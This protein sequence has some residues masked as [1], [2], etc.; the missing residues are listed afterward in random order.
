MVALLIVLA[1]GMCV[2]SCLAS[3]AAV[4]WGRGE[5]ILG[6]S[7]GRSSSHTELASSFRTSI[8]PEVAFAGVSFRH[9]AGQRS[10]GEGE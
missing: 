7:T 1:L 3:V 9:L 5:T 8:P 10:G 6:A 4:A 2:D